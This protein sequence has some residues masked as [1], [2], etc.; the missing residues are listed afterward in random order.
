MILM[1][2]QN[3]NSDLVFSKMGRALLA[4]QRIE[5]LAGEILKFLAEFDEELYH[6]TSDEFLKLSGKTIK[7]KMTLGHIFKLLKLNPGLVIEEELN[8]YL[9]K[10]NVLIHD[11]FSVYL[12]TRSRTQATKAENFCNDF[13]EHSSRMESFFKG[14]LNFLALPKFS[15]DD[16]PYIDESLM[17]KDFEYFISHF[18]K[19]YPVE[20][21]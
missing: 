11:F 13:L 20:E 17:G 1:K 21:I 2:D 12:H 14:F 3:Y 19:Y 5:F 7:I 15:E 6:L 4:A 16:E 9:E 10:R 8:S 18:T